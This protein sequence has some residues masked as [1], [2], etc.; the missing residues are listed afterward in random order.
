MIRKANINDA[1]QIQTLINSYASKNL[2]ISR[3]LDQIFENIRDF[4]VYGEGKKII[5]CCALHVVGWESLAEI[6]SLAVNRLRQK[7]GIGR[8]LVETCLNEA[9]DLK[10]KNVFALTYVPNFFKKFAFRMTSKEKLPHKIWS[11]CCKCPKF[12]G[13]EEEAVIKKI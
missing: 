5:A 6:K 12:P 1:K 7:N 10:I 4:W 2:M 13:C 8:K 11:E 3:S 9:K